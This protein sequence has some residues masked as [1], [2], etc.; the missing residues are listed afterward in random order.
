MST[1]MKLA[2]VAAVISLAGCEPPSIVPGPTLPWWLVFVII[3]GFVLY[4]YLRRG[5]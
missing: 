3:G 4:A 1:G 2:P 5:K